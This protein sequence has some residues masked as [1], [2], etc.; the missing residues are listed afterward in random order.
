MHEYFRLL[1]VENKL[2]SYQYF[3]D[4]MMQHELLDLVEVLPWANKHS[5]EQMRYIIW[6]QLKPYLKNQRL[7]PE[8]LLPLFTDKE[9]NIEKQKALAETEIIDLKKI[10]LEQWTTSN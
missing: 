10:V 7:T 8:K 1:V 5:N 2:V 4:E 9:I 3:M 6:S